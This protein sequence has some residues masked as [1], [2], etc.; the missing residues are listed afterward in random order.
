MSGMIVVQA[1]PATATPASTPTATSTPLAT[2]TPGP[3]NTPGTS[4]PTRTA[5]GTPLATGTPVP[6]ATSTGSTATAAATPIIPG[7]APAATTRLPRTGGGS[8][9]TASMSWLS[10]ALMAAGFLALGAPDR[11]R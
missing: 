9:D 11:T 7:G 5:T 6:S 4:T 1:A 3:T 8:S 2:A 10:T